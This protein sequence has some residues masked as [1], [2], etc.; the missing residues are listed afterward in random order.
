MKILAVYNTD[1]M[2]GGGEISFTLSLRL[3]RE[4]GC[5]VLALIPGAG[6]LAGHL[7]KQQIPYVIAPQESFRH[8]LN[9]RF[10]VEP[11]KEWLDVARD[12]RPDLIHC[13]AIRSALYAQAVARRLNIPTILHARKSETNQVVDCFLLLRLDAI[14]C[15]SEV[16]RRR[17]PTRLAPEKLRVIYN[18]VD[19]GA[20]EKK[21]ARAEALR[22]QWRC[23]PEDLLVGVIGRLSPT[24]GP[25]R[26]LEAAPEILRKAPHTTF[27]MVGTEDPSFPG[28]EARLRGEIARMGLENRFV[29]ARF[30]PEIESI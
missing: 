27:V 20:F 16:V 9:I 26:L 23:E 6:P 13:N 19:L 3:V 21:P 5:E 24:K 10:L 30:E 22:T 29:L 8:G 1:Q 17:F 4:L 28:Y 11:K 7:K 15:I 14:V 25:H 12:F 18:A 2:L